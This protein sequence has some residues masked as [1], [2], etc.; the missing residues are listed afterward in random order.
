MPCPCVQGAGDY[1]LENE[2]LA[3][4]FTMMKRHDALPSTEIYTSMLFA[5]LAV[6]WPALSLWRGMR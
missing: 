2:T 4:T 5:V 6:R 1:L 3:E